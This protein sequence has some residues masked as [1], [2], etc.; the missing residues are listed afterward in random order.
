MAV[1]SNQMEIG[2]SIWSVSENILFEE[3]EKED[4]I[5]QGNLCSL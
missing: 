2:R 4:A 1:N 3:E 5:V